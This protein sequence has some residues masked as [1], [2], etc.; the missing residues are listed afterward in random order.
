MIGIRKP[1]MLKGDGNCFWYSL[2]A[3]TTQQAKHIKASACSLFSQLKPVWLRLQD[4]YSEALWDEMTL[5]QDVWHHSANEITVCAAS[6]V[7]DRP[8]MVLSDAAVSLFSRKELDYDSVKHA[9]LVHSARWSL[10]IQQR[11]CPA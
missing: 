2:E 11:A 9:L 4:F 3:L 10:P 6:V 8:I 7:L 1:L 5:N